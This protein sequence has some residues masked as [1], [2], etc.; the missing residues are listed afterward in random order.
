MIVRSERGLILHGAATDPTATFGPG[1]AVTVAMRP[2]RMEVVRP[3]PTGRRQTA[4]R[5]S[6]G[7]S[8][9]API[10]ATRPSS[11]CSTDQAGELIVRRQNATGAGASQGIGPGDPVTVRWRDEANLVLAG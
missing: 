3:S 5:P 9:R 4:G 10:S 1:Q 6:S 2:E 11:G 8:T 7:G